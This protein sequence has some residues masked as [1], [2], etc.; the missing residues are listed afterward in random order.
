MPQKKAHKDAT[1]HILPPVLTRTNSDGGVAKISCRLLYV[2][3]VLRCYS[4]S[5][6]VISSVGR[7]GDS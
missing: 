1:L 2:S 5:S 4:L 3:R 7:A 6:R